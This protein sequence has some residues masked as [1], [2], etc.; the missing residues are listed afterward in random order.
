MGT[1]DKTKNIF[2]GVMYR[3]DK[4]AFV[5]QC[6][7]RNEKVYK[8]FSTENEA[9]AFYW[10]TKIEELEKFRD[11]ELRLLYRRSELCK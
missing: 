9:V 2:I 8:S 5:A 11:Q 7:L 6:Q 3:E 1:V 4:K 10:K